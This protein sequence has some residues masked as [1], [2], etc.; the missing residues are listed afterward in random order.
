[1]RELVE[2]LL[3]G[4]L[5]RRNETEQANVSPRIVSESNA[6]KQVG[7]YELQPKSTL[8]VYENTN[9]TTTYVDRLLCREF[10]YVTIR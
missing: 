7:N 4:I 1:M 9:A 10:M 5:V 3:V 2:K 6:V 8:C